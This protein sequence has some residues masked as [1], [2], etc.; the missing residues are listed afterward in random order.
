MAEWHGVASR[1]GAARSTTE[2]WGWSTAPPKTCERQRRS[3][4]LTQEAGPSWTRGAA[5]IR[6][7]FAPRFPP[8]LALRPPWERRGRGGRCYTRKKY[9]YKMDKKREGGQGKRGR[10]GALRTLRGKSFGAH[11]AVS[12]GGGFEGRLCLI[13]FFIIIIT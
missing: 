3:L 6:P 9:K 13:L 10:G 4:L 8:S 1:S 5:R 11:G 2:E 7:G 12:S